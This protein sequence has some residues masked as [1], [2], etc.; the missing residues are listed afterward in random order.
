MKKR[1]ETETDK[2]GDILRDVQK[3]H[4]HLDIGRGIL[5][6]ENRLK[7]EIKTE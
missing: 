2:K 3:K 7:T 5:Y 4:T 1:R 6:K